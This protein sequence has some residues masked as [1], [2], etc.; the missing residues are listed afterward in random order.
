M[1]RQPTSSTYC[2]L[3][4]KARC[5]QRTR[6][7]CVMWQLRCGAVLRLVINERATMIVI[8]YA[9]CCPGTPFL[10]SA[11]IMNDA[12]TAPRSSANA[13]DCSR[14]RRACDHCYA[15]LTGVPAGG[16]ACQLVCHVQA[17]LTSS[18]WHVLTR[19]DYANGCRAACMLPLCFR[20]QAWRRS[21]GQR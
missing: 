8:V 18:G 2:L 10:V 21:S 17:C 3:V 14:C 12:E 6:L 16:M 15:S 20:V 5:D 11:R 13:F 1:S 4:A 19:A 9:E 7:L